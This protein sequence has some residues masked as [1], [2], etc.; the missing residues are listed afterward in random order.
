MARLS[1][2]EG[3]WRYK[4]DN[5]SSIIS[6]GFE[7][8][9]LVAQFPTFLERLYVTTISL[10]IALPPPLPFWILIFDISSGN[11]RDPNNRSAPVNGSLADYSSPPILVAGAVFVF[12]PPV[13]AYDLTMGGQQ[14]Q[15]EPFD[16]GIL[17]IP[18]FTPVFLSQIPAPAGTSGIISTRARGTTPTEIRPNQRAQAPCGHV[19]GQIA[20]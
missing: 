4:T 7:E 5:T 3:A 19:I 13:K 17:V 8:F 11:P 2:R 20:R 12:E 9:S 14:F 10:P 15:G 16:S 1:Q 6:P 18:S